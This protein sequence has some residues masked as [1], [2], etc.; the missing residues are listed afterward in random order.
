[1]VPL[2]YPSHSAR[3]GARPGCPSRRATRRARIRERQDGRHR[4]PTRR[5]TCRPRGWSS[6]SRSLAV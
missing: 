4:R 1:L 5:A 3:R 6:G 2:M